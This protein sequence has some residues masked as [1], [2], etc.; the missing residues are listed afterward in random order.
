M[1]LSSVSGAP[2]GSQTGPRGELV[3]HHPVRARRR[4]EPVRHRDRVL[5]RE[6]DPDTADR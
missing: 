4:G 6:V 3:G 1:S 5:D 2:T